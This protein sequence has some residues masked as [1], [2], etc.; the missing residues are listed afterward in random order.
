MIGDM[1]IEIL[2]EFVKPH[3]NLKYL[4]VSNNQLGDRALL[5]IADIVAFNVSLQVLFC[6]GNSF[7]GRA[8]PSL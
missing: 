1:G 5:A 2:A 4:D 6:E 8:L 3:Q 7:M